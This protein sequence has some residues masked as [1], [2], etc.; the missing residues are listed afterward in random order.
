MMDTK[1]ETTIQGPEFGDAT[2][3]MANQADKNMENDLET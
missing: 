1:M 3:V 2:P